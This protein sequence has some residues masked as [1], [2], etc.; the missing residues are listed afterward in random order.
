M[1]LSLTLTKIIEFDWGIR[2]LS[3]SR[4]I[5]PNWTDKRLGI[6]IRPPH[7]QQNTEQVTILKNHSSTN[8]IRPCKNSRKQG[9][10]RENHHF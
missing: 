5:S 3:I 4:S 9:L 2:I 8:Q 1:K 6:R 10:S 7:K